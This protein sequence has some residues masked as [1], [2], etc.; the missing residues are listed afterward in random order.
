MRVITGVARGR[1]LTTLD[2]LDT[3]PTSQR[4]KEAL[5]SVIQF[6]IEGRRVLDLFAGSGQLGIEALSR[7]ADRAVFVDSSKKA[8]AVINKNIDATG[9]SDRSAVLCREWEAYLLTARERFNLVFLDPP[10]GKDILLKA[11]PLSA[12][13]LEQGGIIVCEHDRNDSL[14]ERFDGLVLFRKKD[15]GRTVFSFYR[16]ENEIS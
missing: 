3:R 16:K 1:V 15:Y 12:Q 8:V 2:G 11:V 13:K 4:N 5:F 14:P 6:D 9:F 10:Y 7:G